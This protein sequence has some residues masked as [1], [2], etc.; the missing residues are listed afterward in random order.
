MSD[1][2]KSV[3][4]KWDR[5]L[6][7]TATSIATGM[8]IGIIASVGIFGRRP[9]PVGLG[10]GFGAGN[11]FATCKFDFTHPDL[12]HG[13]VQLKQQVQATTQADQ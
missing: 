7:Y 5:C 9:W 10:V 12:V 1:S 6:T 13:K 2:V 3:D 4:D 11:G 8:A